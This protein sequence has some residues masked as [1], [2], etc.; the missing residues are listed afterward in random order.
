MPPASLSTL[1]VMM[2]GPITARTSTRRI[3][4]DRRRVSTGASVGP[5]QDVDYVI[6]GGDSPQPAGPLHPRERQQGVIF[7]KVRPLNRLRGPEA[8]GKRGQTTGTEHPPQR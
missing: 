2:P 7:Q 1:A 8:G 5:P 3:F 4:H 6:G